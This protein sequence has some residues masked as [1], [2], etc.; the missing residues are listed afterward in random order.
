MNGAVGRFKHM[1]A[2]EQV[3][4]LK[5]FIIDIYYIISILI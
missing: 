3:L 4:G 1:S 2:R 5:L